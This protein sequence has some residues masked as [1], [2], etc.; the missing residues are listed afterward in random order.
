MKSHTGEY[1]F[2]CDECGK[3]YNSQKKLTICKNNHAG[4]FNL[5][6]TLCDFKT[7]CAQNYRR[8]L[9][10]HSTEKPFICPICAHTSTHVGALSSHI[11]KCHKLTLTQAEVLSKRTRL[12]A[13]MTD[14]EIEEVKRRG[15]ISL[16]G[17][18]TVRSREISTGYSSNSSINKINKK[19]T[20]VKSQPPGDD[21][22]NDGPPTL[23][24]PPSRLLYPYF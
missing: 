1:K 20:P 6:C 10:T 8:H 9:A 19:T 3:G 7:N 12:G 21:E 23:Y 17:A 18:D 4:I 22:S 14:T 5:R 24:P 2:R 13:P 15:D 16:K 11:R